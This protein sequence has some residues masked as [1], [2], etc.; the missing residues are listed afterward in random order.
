[1]VRSSFDAPALSEEHIRWHQE[2]VVRCRRA[3]IQMTSLAASGHP[4]GSLS[5]L[6]LYLVLWSCA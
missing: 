5:S 2:A 1:M 6:D 4:G 3:I